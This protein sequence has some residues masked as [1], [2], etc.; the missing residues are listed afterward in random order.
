MKIVREREMDT[1]S[2]GSL[3]S[4]TETGLL[5]DGAGVSRVAERELG[6]SFKKS[7][8]ESLGNIDDG[9]KGVIFFGMSIGDIVR[10]KVIVV[11]V[12][13][14]GGIIGFTILGVVARGVSTS[15]GG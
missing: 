7:L 6:K 12:D 2:L 14:K 4:S 9:W 8:L 3:S 1:F 5:D 15:S 10:V 13:L 11:V